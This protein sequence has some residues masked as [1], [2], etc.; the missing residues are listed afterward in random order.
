MKS[1]F[2]KKDKIYIILYNT[3]NFLTLPKINTKR[4]GFYSFSFRATQLRNHLLMRN[5]QVLEQEIF[6]ISY[7]V[8]IYVKIIKL[9]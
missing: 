6:G 5:L 7:L 9:F 2:T 4:F 3:L 8:S 1:I